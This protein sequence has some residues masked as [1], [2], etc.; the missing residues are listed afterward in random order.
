MPGAWHEAGEEHAKVD[1]GVVIIGGGLGRAASMVAD[2]FA[3]Y[4][5]VRCERDAGHGTLG[6][7]PTAVAV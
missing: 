7:N 3:R 1:D 6:D 2:A 5:P 4:Q